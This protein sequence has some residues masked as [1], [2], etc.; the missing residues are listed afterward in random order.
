MSQ[1]LG[2][3]VILSLFL[4]MMKTLFEPY[5]ASPEGLQS[6]L[7]RISAI[8]LPAADRRMICR[9]MLGFLDMTTLEGSDTDEKVR[10]LCRTARFS[11]DNP[12]L[13]DAAA[14]CVYPSLVRVARES[15]AGTSIGVASVAG[16]FPAGQ[17]SLGIKLEELKWAIGEGADEIDTVISRGKLTEGKAGEVFDEI[18]AMK[19]AC[20]RIHL[21]VILETGELPSIGMIRQAAAIAIEAGA[22]FIKTSTGKISPGAAPL[23]FLVM[24]DTIREFLEKT[25]KAIGIKP[26]GGIRE[27]E[28]AL[29]YY[30]MVEDVLGEDWLDREYFRI[31]ASSLAKELIRNV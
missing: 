31:G 12:S 30:L 27:S 3:F 19:E 23:A 1:R 22:D 6:R 21:K 5:L 8:R 20:G 2:F 17:T 10:Q 15:L 13:P 28:Q 7:D 11:L 26:A 24:L 29:L 4:S 9:K 16:G 18:A 25:G 14:V